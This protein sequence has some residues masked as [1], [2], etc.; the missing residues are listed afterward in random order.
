MAA[1]DIE[2]FALFTTKDMTIY[3]IK[4]VPQFYW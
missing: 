1:Q 3:E 2:I 4:R